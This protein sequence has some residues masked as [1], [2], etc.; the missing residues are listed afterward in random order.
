MQFSSMKGT[1]S[2]P[3][4]PHIL[5]YRTNARCFAGETKSESIFSCRLSKE[6]RQQENQPKL[7]KAGSGEGNGKEGRPRHQ[8]SHR[9]MLSTH[10]KYRD[11]P[12]S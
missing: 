12:Y 11:P 3:S 6:S 10:K 1:N 4:N 9:G 7:G 8:G 5:V 2:R